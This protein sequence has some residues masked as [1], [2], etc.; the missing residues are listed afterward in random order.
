MLQRVFVGTETGRRP[1]FLFFRRTNAEQKLRV[2][3]FVLNIRE[4]V[5]FPDDSALFAEE[6]K[7]APDTEK[8]PGHGEG[9]VS[10]I[11]LFASRLTGPAC[12]SRNA[13]MG[14]R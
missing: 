11:V 4:R 13:K 10:G 9:E 5:M 6:Y 2:L 3:C 8:H 12:V 1:P 14:M 7:K